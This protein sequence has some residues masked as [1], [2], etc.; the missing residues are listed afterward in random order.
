MQLSLSGHNENDHLTI[1]I[2]PEL[3]NQFEVKEEKDERQGKASSIY[4]SN[5]NSI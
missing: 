3:I 5:T 4:L 2:I 1:T